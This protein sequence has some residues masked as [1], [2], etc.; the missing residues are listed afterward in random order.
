MIKKMASQLAA[1]NRIAIRKPPE[2]V[3]EAQP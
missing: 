2:P 1:E 3:T